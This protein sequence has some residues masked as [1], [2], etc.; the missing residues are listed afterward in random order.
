[1]NVTRVSPLS[2][3][4]NNVLANP[5]GTGQTAVLAAVAGKR[6][7][8]LSCIVIATLANN[9]KFQS[10]STDI[11]ALFPLGAN[12]G[13][14]FPFNEHGWFE[15]AVGEALNIN[16]SVATATAVQIQYIELAFAQP[17]SGI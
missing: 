12:G 16:M 1:M 8:V 10:N 7:R 17:G 13:F 5:S 6:Y 15:T 2:S 9:V 14:V 11:T 4:H 3:A